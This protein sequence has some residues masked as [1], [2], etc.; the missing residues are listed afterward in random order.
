MQNALIRGMNY[1]WWISIHSDYKAS[2]ILILYTIVLFNIF[3]AKDK[4]SGDNFFQQS[5]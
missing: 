4:T 3:E 2:D 1:E 5:D